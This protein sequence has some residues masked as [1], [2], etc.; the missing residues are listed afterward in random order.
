ME[1]LE[2]E[3]EILKLDVFSN[4]K[5]LKLCAKYDQSTGK[6][7]VVAILVNLTGFWS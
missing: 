1:E 7:S 4:R 2:S 5:T 6:N 3:V